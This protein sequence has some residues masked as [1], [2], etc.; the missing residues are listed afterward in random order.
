MG[1]RLSSLC[2]S[3]SS[4]KPASILCACPCLPFC[5]P[6]AYRGKPRPL[7]QQPSR[8]KVTQP[9]EWQCTRSSDSY[10]QFIASSEAHL[11]F[12]GGSHTP[13]RRTQN[14]QPDPQRNACANLVAVFSLLRGAGTP[15]SAGLRRGLSP[16][17]SGLLRTVSPA[18]CVQGRVGEESGHRPQG[19]GF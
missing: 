19:G 17:P 16:T 10:T 7:E 11:S 5:M 3:F 9:G 14:S 6:P 2:C 15:G 12:G 13:P 1:E 18:F 8:P 4:V